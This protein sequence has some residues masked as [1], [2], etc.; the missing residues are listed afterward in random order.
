MKRLLITGI[1][2]IY[3]AGCSKGANIDLEGA[4]RA[5]R[6][7]LDGYKVKWG[8]YKLTSPKTMEVVRRYLGEKYSVIWKG[9]TNADDVTDYL[10]VKRSARYHKGTVKGLIVDEHG[11]VYMD[12]D[13]AN[14]FRAQGKLF[15]DFRR[16]GLKRGD[17]AVVRL[18]FEDDDDL[19]LTREDYR[20]KTEGLNLA[21]DKHYGVV[22][23]FA[24]Q[25]IDHDGYV[26]GRSPF[27]K[28][29]ENRFR[30]YLAAKVNDLYKDRVK[31]AYWIF[32]PREQKA[33]EL[34]KKWVALYRRD[35]AAGKAPRAVNFDPEALR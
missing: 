9:D 15:Y 14:G 20:K 7:F 23:G 19:K 32:S 28:Q 18:L 27:L 10:V 25:L 16:M 33:H 31:V 29:K 22:G 24:F 35:K 17:V 11:K 6:I 8:D 30:T 13:L 4:K 21:G 2:L 26:I 3:I 12:Y 5:G 34:Y 1:L